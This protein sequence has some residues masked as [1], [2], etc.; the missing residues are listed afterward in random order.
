MNASD[1]DA[2]PTDDAVDEAAK[3]AVEDAATLAK[4]RTALADKGIDLAVKDSVSNDAVFTTVYGDQALF[5]DD[6]VKLADGYING[7]QAGSIYSYLGY[8]D[9]L[10]DVSSGATITGNTIVKDVATNTFY[11]FVGTAEEGAAITDLSGIDFGND[12]N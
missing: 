4:L 6:T 10:S 5:M 12:E 11:E 9:Y 2:D 8:H 3:D 7:G 1:D